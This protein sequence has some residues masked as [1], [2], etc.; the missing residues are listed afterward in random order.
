VGDLFV[1][2]M[3]D[4]PLKEAY[5]KFNQR[6]FFLASSGIIAVY[7]EISPY[8]S[9]SQLQR[10]IKR[11]ALRAV[12]KFKDEA[13]TQPHIAV[14]IGTARLG[15]NPY[16]IWSEVP[17]S[18]GGRALQLSTLDPLLNL[19]VLRT[20]RGVFKRKNLLSMDLDEQR[21]FPYMSYSEQFTAW[22]TGREDCASNGISVVQPSK[23]MK[24][25]NLRK[26]LDLPGSQAIMFRKQPAPPGTS[27]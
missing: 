16:S 20:N 24:L 18:T 1:Q 11:A 27:A 2:A 14:A 21:Q 25:V 13:G 19:T 26:F 12:E 10:V 8:L 5:N 15:T 23:T 9:G 22:F 3:T 7:W 17:V 6:R 4:P